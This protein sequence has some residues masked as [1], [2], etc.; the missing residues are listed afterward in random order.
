MSAS[1]SKVIT[2]LLRNPGSLKRVRTKPKL[3]DVEVIKIPTQT[4]DYNANPLLTWE[5]NT[6]DKCLR[7]LPNAVNFRV[8]IDIANALKGQAAT[9]SDNTK[10]ADGLVDEDFTRDSNRLCPRHNWGRQ[11]LFNPLSSPIPALVSEVEILINGILVQKDSSGLLSLYAQLNRVFA[12]RRHREAYVGHEHVLHS[13]EDM[14]AED[15]KGLK[16][17]KTIS[18]SFMYALEQLDAE[19]LPI[20]GNN[21]GYS[22]NLSGGIDGCF[23]LG[24][25]KN[26]TLQSMAGEPPAPP[27]MVIIPPNSIVTIRMRINDQIHFRMIDNAIP[28]NQYMGNDITDFT[29]L[30]KKPDMKVSIH[31]AYLLA[32]KIRPEGGEK[33]SKQLN[34]AGKYFFDMPVWRYSAIPAEQQHTVVRERFPP[35]VTIVYCAFLKTHQ[36]HRDV[37]DNLFSDLTRFNLPLQLQKIVFKVNGS[38]VLFENGLE[39]PQKERHAQSDARL[40]YTYMRNRNITTDSFESFFPR[41]D[42][43]SGFKQAFV[44]DLLPFQL[45]DVPIE[46]TAEI[47]WNAV[48]TKNWNLAMVAPIEAVVSKTGDNLSTWESSANVT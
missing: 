25:S 6:G 39:L 21:A 46:V 12:S 37:A 16:F 1:E 40:L 36:I 23:L 33:L 11:L 41:G 26:L 9:V 45:Q 18:P 43:C 20:A 22:V 4:V 27:D 32:Q 14:Q 34:V 35:N 24:G 2:P 17:K 48:S 8:T 19:K 47:T 29:A 42:T 30:N 7:F 15:T 44:L 13:S 3:A 31:E 28:G 38:P 5:I 10:A